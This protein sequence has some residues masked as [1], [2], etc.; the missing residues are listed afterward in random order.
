MTRREFMARGNLLTYISWPLPLSKKEDSSRSGFLSR[1]F[2][3]ATA[4]NLVVLWPVETE[5]STARP[6]ESRTGRVTAKPEILEWL[7]VL[8]EAS[9]RGR[10]GDVRFRARISIRGINPFVIVS[11]KRAASLCRQWRRPM[12]V[13]VRVNGA[14]KDGV[15]TNLMPKGDGSF[16]LYLNTTMRRVGRSEIGNVVDVHLA[17]DSTYRPGPAHPMPAPFRAA[18]AINAAAAAGWDKLT[19]SRKK[20]ILRYF[21][22]LKAPTTLERNVVKATEVL[23]GK[24][25]RFMARQWNEDQG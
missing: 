19:P 20:E 21:A 24:R 1:W 16:Y 25:A 23:A 22:T 2:E 5:R 15:K 10:M 9:P 4:D 11:Q 12:P 18:L 17:A 7:Q 8:S 13:T 3:K 14:P 6:A